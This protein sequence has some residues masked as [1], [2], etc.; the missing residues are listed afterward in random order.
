MEKIKLMTVVG[1]RPEI[2]R[3]S[4]TIKQI[5][6]SSVF[7]HKFVHTGQNYDYEL[8]Q[9]FFEDL[10]LRQPDYYLDAVGDT[11]VQTIANIMLKIEPIIQKNKPDAFMVLGDTNS[12][13][14]AIVAKKYKIPIFHLEAG[15]RCFDQRVPEEINRKIIDHISD[16]N[17]TYSQ[18]A[19]EYLLSEGFPADQ[20]IVTGS[21][22]K[23]V[24]DSNQQKIAKSNI[25][26]KL[27]LKKNQYFLV[28][29]HREESVDNPD[30]LLQFI[31]VLDTLVE[32]YDYPIL[33]S[34]HPRT[35]N[36][37]NALNISMNPKI[38]INK[39]LNFT[40]Y[41][42][43]QIHAKTVLSDSGTISE[44]SSILNL[45]ALNLREA[46]E[47][48][49]AME[50]AEVILTGYDKNRII[51]GLSV[52]KKNTHTGVKDYNVDNFSDKIV[53]III[54]YTDYIQRKTWKKYENRT[55]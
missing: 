41:V 44:E 15:N 23:E 36:Q 18:I 5:D 12:A 19:R 43:L 54:S 55:N 42:H 51:Q 53:R 34:T 3:L 17:L 26:N 4:E 49:E 48:P 46:H 25:L 24:L 20:I 39:P 13:L 11:A 45:N 28:S 30:K 32:M 8:N 33:F 10:E 35:L 47:R 38:I 31:N 29:S 1:T 52:V 50:E 40:D 6:G 21:P 22:M 16:M 9:I 14:S 27:N 2:I 7:D 37:I